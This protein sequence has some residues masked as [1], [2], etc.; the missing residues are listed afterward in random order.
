M[1]LSNIYDTTMF[2]EKPDSPTRPYIFI[3]HSDLR[4]ETGEFAIAHALL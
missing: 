4:F 3:S 2:V 1:W